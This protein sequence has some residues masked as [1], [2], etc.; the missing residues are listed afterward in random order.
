MTLVYGIFL[1]EIKVRI[2]AAEFTTMK[3][4]VD[5]Q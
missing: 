2:D 3:M 1:S 5:G 4:P